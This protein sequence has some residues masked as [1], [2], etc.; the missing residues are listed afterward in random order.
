MHI[1]ILT[2]SIGALVLPLA[3]PVHA[4]SMHPTP[5]TAVPAYVTAAINDPARA[6]DS[7]DKAIRMDAKQLT[8]ILV[9]T[10]IKPGDTVVE[11]VPGSG[12]WTRLFSQMVKPKG[13][14]YTVWPEQM[15]KYS[16]KSLQEWK[17]LS[18]SG[19]Y[20]DVHVLEQ[21]AQTVAAP[22]KADVVFTADNYHDYHNMKGVDMAKFDKSVFD[23]LK[24]GGVFIVIDH[25]APAGSGTSDT[26][27][28]HR[29]DPAAVKKEL[30][31]AGF[32][33]A[34]S[35]DALHNPKDPLNNKIFDKSIRG[36]TDQFVFRF[37]KPM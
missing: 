23:A 28:L 22:A 15:L 25:A 29:I 34:G 5:N 11:L 2:L 16:S 6:E 14:V 32:V 3:L 1:S 36:Q 4:Q 27:T 13:T 33:F 30:E 35:S 12:Y 9:F 21:D 24:P 20:G 7:V 26:D 31:S 18:A 19:H 17:T 10:G 37:R 8:D